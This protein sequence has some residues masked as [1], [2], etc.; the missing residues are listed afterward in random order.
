MSAIADKK[1]L[2]VE[3]DEW[4]I[5]LA[6]RA[7]D[8]FGFAARLETAPDGQAALDMLRSGPLPD[9]VLTDIKMPRINGLELQEKLRADERLQGLKVAVLTSSAEIGDRER[10]LA[11]GALAFLQ[12]PMELDAWK[13]VIETLRQLLA[14]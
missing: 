5:E 13:P 12:K 1:V 14:G 3:D 7:F 2:Y 10:A 11:H 6:K 8:L 9:L 4:D